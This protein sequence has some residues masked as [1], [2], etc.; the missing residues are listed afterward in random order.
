MCFNIGVIIGPLLGGLLADPVGN[1]PSV[2][3][4]GTLLGGEDGVWWMRRW[5]YSLPNTVSSFYLFSAAL[6]V[7]LCLEEVSCAG[8]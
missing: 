5:P 7:W 8:F 4:P 1:Y 6:M 3:G 2:F